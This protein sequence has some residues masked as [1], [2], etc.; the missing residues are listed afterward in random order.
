MKDEWQKLLTVH[1][2]GTSWMT[3]TA[4]TSSTYFCFP[5]VGKETLQHCKE[6]RAQI[7]NG[8]EVNIPS[9]GMIGSGCLHLQFHGLCPKED[10]S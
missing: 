6:M 9:P 8:Y 3:S 7:L 2:Q 4:P 10:T 5:M 1:V